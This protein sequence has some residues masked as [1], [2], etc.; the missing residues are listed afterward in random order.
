MKQFKAKNSVF[1]KGNDILRFYCRRKDLK[2]ISYF[3]RYSFQRTLKDYLL[4]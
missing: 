2:L 3:W 4:R 1:F